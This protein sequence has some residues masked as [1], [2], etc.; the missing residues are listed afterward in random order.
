MIDKDGLRREVRLQA[1][2]LLMVEFMS[3]LQFVMKLHGA[4]DDHLQKADEGFL[5]IF[6]KNGLDFLPPEASDL[7][8]GELEQQLGHLLNAARELRF[9]REAAAKGH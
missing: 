3:R 1:L 9:D 7:V 6:R 5:D 4:D 8:M 2:E